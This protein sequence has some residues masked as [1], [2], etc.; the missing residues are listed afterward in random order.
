MYFYLCVC[1]Y[2]RSCWSSKCLPFELLADLLALGFSCLAFPSVLTFPAKSALVSS[3]PFQ[4]LSS[5]F[6]LRFQSFYGFLSFLVSITSSLFLTVNMHV[7]SVHCCQRLLF[8]NLFISRHYPHFFW[9]RHALKDAFKNKNVMKLNEWE[10]VADKVEGK[11]FGWWQKSSFQ[12]TVPVNYLEK[13]QFF[14]WM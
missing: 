14:I 7:T 11:G 13:V 3:S 5:F 6:F 2:I 10:I 4:S 8:L 9:L 1:V 12:K